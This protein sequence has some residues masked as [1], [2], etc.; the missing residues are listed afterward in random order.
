MGTDFQGVITKTSGIQNSVDFLVSELSTISSDL[1]GGSSL[2]VIGLYINTAITE[3]QTL[4]VD[5]S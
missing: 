5:A 1:D 3:V 4:G 2:P